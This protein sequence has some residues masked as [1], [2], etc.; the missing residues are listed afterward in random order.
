MLMTKVLVIV[1]ISAMALGFALSVARLY[2][3]VKGK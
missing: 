2:M 1:G 3:A